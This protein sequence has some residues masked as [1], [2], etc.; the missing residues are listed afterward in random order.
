[1]S[2]VAAVLRRLRRGAVAVIVAFSMIV[3]LG[4]GAL[5]LDIGYLHVVGAQLQAS[6]DA[7]ALAAATGMGQDETT[8]RARATALAAL[9]TA[10]G[11]TVELAG[12]D[13]D[14]GTWDSATSTFT[15]TT[16][17]NADVVR[18]SYEIDDLS[19]WLSRVLGQETLMVA[20]SAV[21]GAGE[22]NTAV[23]AI[24]ADTNADLTGNMTVDSWDS[25]EG[26]YEE[27]AG[28]EGNVCSNGDLS[29][30]GSAVVMGSIYAGPDGTLSAGCSVSGEE[31][32]LEDEIPLPSVSCASA[33]ASNKNSTVS[34]YLKGYNFKAV[35]K[36]KVTLAAGTYYFH[37]FA[38][39]AGA[40]ITV[41][42]DVTIC[43]ETGTVSLNGDSFINTSK[44]PSALTL[45]VADDSKVTLNGTSSFYGSVI[46]PYST[47]VKLNGTFDF[48]GIV[49]ADELQ[50]NGNLELHADVSLME[51]YEGTVSRDPPRLVF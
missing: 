14:F 45:Q 39:N 12:A 4:F 44:Q 13:I 49:I 28:S 50:I 18:V 10:G 27:T 30:G 36:D 38:V 5:V 47:Q 34:K 26:T 32:H 24:L 1:M 43:V 20:R 19:P 51:E 46:A 41:S 16:F 25:S 42:P 3:I 7:A 6:L 31:S 23:C 9:N 2:R 40:Q 48:Y 33:K 35:S 8:A 15:E 21:A 29:C 11:E 17:A 22:A 37:D